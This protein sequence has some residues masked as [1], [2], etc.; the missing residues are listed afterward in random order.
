MARPTKLANFKR[1]S[2]RVPADLLKAVK[3]A[4][5]DEDLSVNDWILRAMRLQIEK[6]QR[7]STSS[8][9]QRATG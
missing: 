4:C 8:S 1:F 3:H 7:Q 6:Q 5:V 2:L 9:A